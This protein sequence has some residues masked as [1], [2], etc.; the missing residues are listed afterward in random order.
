MDFLSYAMR[1]ANYSPGEDVVGITWNTHFTDLRVAITN[2]SDD[3]YHDLDIFIQPDKW[4]YKALMITK[5]SGC[6][7]TPIPGN[8]FQTA[9][10]K[11]GTTS[12]TSTRIGDGFDAHD[13]QG[14]VFTP[15]AKETG[16]RLRCSVFPAHYTAEVIFAL[17][18]LSPRLP[19]PK[20][21]PGK[22]GMA[23][24]EIAGAD[25]IFDIL[26]DRPFPLVTL[27]SGSYKR[28]LKKY[29]IRRTIPVSDGN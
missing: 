1:K 13:N 29:S 16:S 23:I 27:M 4:N 25:S 26:D 2:P 7:L 21:S 9:R 24:A 15:L 28:N 12:I 6:D 19:M 22:M 10:A 14:D 17:V 5:L 18:A 11:G 20:P 3:D 8:V